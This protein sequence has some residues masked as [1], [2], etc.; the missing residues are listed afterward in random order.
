MKHDR[1]Q[2]YELLHRRMDQYDD[3][4]PPSPAIVASWKEEFNRLLDDDTKSATTHQ[5][6]LTLKALAV[7]GSHAFDRMLGTGSQI[8]LETFNDLVG[9]ATGERSQAGL[10]PVRPRLDQ[11][12]A[13]QDWDIACV[14]VALENGYDRYP[15]FASWQRRKTAKSVKTIRKMI[16]NIGQ[17]KGPYET[18]KI[19]IEDIKRWLDRGEHWMFDD[20]LGP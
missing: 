10:D 7:G 3:A 6:R 17:E 18:I 5:Q 1:S 12:S 19:N 16:D 15:G 13:Q 9:L 20:L 4:S 11:R 8:N 2:A 14:I